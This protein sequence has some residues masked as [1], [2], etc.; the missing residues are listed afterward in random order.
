MAAVRPTAPRPEIEPRPVV[1]ICLMADV[2]VTVCCDNSATCHVTV[3]AGAG[4]ARVSV[5]APPSVI[6]ERLAADLPRAI[7]M[8]AAAGVAAWPATVA[9]SGPD[10]PPDPAALRLE[11]LRLWG[12]AP[13][14]CAPRAPRGGNQPSLALAPSLAPAPSLALAPRPGARAVSEALVTQMVSTVAAYMAQYGAAPDFA[15][16]RPSVREKVYNYIR[17]TTAKPQAPD[18]VVEEVRRRLAAQ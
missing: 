10:A 6:G 16:T 4:W 18:E 14:P 7:A 1:L 2:S 12:G 13:E 17:S 5:H 11:A 8:L 3:T 15:A 9:V